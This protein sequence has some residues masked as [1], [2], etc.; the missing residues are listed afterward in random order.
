MTPGP[1]YLWTVLRD[2]RGGI[3][4]AAAQIDVTP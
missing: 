2:D 3:D 4:F 1:A